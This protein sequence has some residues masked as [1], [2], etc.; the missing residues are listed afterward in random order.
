MYP[1]AEQEFRVALQ[2][3]PDNASLHSALGYVLHEQKAWDRAAAEY[4]TAI[5]L[6]PDVAWAHAVLGVALAVKGE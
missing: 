2:L 4:R 6:Q 5:R 1:E 3:D